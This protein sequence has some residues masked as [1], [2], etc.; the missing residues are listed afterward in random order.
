MW[1]IVRL[2]VCFCSCSYLCMCIW[3]TADQMSYLTA[4]TT[5]CIFGRLLPGR[6]KVKGVSHLQQAFCLFKSWDVLCMSVKQHSYWP[7]RLS[8]CWMNICPLYVF[9]REQKEMPK[10]FQLI[11]Y[12]DQDEH[13]GWWSSSLRDSI[14]PQAC[15]MHYSI[16]KQ[17]WESLK[18]RQDGQ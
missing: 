8:V 1:T 16:N 10:H 11:K 6:G 4:N 13:K 18:S 12:C 9:V 14:A 15:L 7:F 17:R 2:L 5:C 3:A